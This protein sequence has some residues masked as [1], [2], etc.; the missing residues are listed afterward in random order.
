MRRLLSFPFL[1][2]VR[3]S[4]VLPR[5]LPSF[6]VWSKPNVTVDAIDSFYMANGLP[7]TDPKSG[8]NEQDLYK[9]RD[10]RLGWSVVLPGSQYGS[11]TYIP[12]TDQV[13]CGARPRKYADIGSTNVDDYSINTI[14][15][16]YAD[17]L[18]FRAEALIEQGQTGQEV[19]NLIDQVRARVGMPKVADVEGTGLS[20]EEL[21]KILRHERRV[22]F[23]F[24]GER[25]I[26]ML[27]WK[28]PSLVHNVIGY[29]R[30]LLS[31]PASLS[32]W[33]FKKVLVEER[34]FD[35]AKGFLWPIPLDDMQNNENLTQNPGY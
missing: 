30:S 26:D 6:T 20:K 4:V 24:E 14:V 12:A 11:V 29:D 9:N 2:L 32:T 22:E 3:M 25:Y 23:F 5:A 1:I 18:L 15:L 13:P 21:R 10:P 7:I 17:I 27:R 8:Y 31:N 19:Y 34:K 35:S 28:D 33:T 16:R